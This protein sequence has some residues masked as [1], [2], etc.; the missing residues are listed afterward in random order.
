MRMK[1]QEERG[2]ELPDSELDRVNGGSASATPDRKDISGTRPMP[3][4]AAKDTKQIPIESWS[5]G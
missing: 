3:T 2:Q 4:V 5:W 1:T